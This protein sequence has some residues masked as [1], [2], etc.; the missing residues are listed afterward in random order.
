MQ[1]VLFLGR[2]M[3][4]KVRG[5]VRGGPNEKRGNWG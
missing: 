1:T 2:Q 3:G 5:T 4:V